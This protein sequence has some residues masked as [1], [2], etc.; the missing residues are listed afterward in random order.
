[1]QLLKL[2]TTSV[3]IFSSSPT[4]HLHVFY[5]KYLARKH[6]LNPV[7]PS[8]YPHLCLGKSLVNLCL[9]SLHRKKKKKKP[10]KKGERA[11]N[12]SFLFLSYASSS[13]AAALVPFLSLSAELKQGLAATVQV[14]VEEKHQLCA[15]EH[16]RMHQRTG[17]AHVKLQRVRKD[18]QNIK[19][20]L[21]K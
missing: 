1:M 4:F 6:L 13:S 21:I 17:T 19:L 20:N 11:A 7:F 10:E 16:V 12:F 3:Y 14:Q 8:V 5:S 15:C 18:H 9:S 2:V